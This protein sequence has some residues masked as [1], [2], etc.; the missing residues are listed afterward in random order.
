MTG[1]IAA[2]MGRLRWPPLW[3]GADRWHP[4]AGSAVRAV[5]A[6][7]TSACAGCTDGQ[8][9]PLFRAAARNY[10]KQFGRPCP[11]VRPAAELVHPIGAGIDTFEDPPGVPGDASPSGG[12]YPANGAMT[13]QPNNP[14]GTWFETCTLSAREKATCTVSLNA[15][16][17]AYGAR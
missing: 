7:E 15:F 4:A 6:S 16:L 13:Y 14:N 12:A 17:A 9:C 3:R 2:T 10:A 1:Q 5:V 11:A 8:A